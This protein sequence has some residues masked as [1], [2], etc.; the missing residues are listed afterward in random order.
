MKRQF[1]SGI[2]I[3]EVLVVVAVVALIAGLGY[4]F[5]TRNNQ[6]VA[7]TQDDGTSQTSNPATTE[8]V[9]KIETTDDL[10]KA[11]KELDQLE[12]DDTSDDAS[13]NSS[14]SDL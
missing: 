7:S 3:V 10:D 1:N 13:L 2:S 9:T 6:P 12:T 11:T 4:V 5:F 14:M 8:E